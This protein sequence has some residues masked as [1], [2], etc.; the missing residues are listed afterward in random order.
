MREWWRETVEAVGARLVVPIHW[1][2]FLAPSE[3][4]PLPMAR[5]MD[6]Y[7]RGMR[8]LGALARESGVEIGWMPVFEPIAVL[9]RD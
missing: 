4:A 6:D 7:P 5:Y 2:D 8:R 3:P 9:A 1:D